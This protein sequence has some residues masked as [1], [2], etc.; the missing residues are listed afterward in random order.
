M[1]PKVLSPLKT[2]WSGSSHLRGVR[3][4]REFSSDR[5]YSWRVS[6]LPSPWEGSRRTVGRPWNFSD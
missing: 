3:G 1:V 5:T 2:L 4:A 6:S